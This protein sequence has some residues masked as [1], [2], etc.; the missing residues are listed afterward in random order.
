[1]NVT[2]LGEVAVC[3]D[4]TPRSRTVCRRG[5]DL[6]SV[7][8]DQ[9]TKP[10]PSCWHRVVSDSN[11]SSRQCHQCICSSRRLKSAGRHELGC[12]Q[13]TDELT[14]HAAGWRLAS[15]QCMGETDSSTERNLAEPHA[16]GVEDCLSRR[17]GRVRS[18]NYL[19][20]HSSV[21]DA[22]TPK[23]C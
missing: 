3:Q 20:N 17:T 13:H 8:K 21:S 4:L 19:R 23:V 6:K 16:S 22:L 1:V 18:D 11:P 15:Q 12:R 14:T 5:P 2:A 7:V 9:R 10:F